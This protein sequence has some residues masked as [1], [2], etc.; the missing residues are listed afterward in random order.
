MIYL[1]SDTHF[2]HKNIIRYCNRPF[3]NVDV[4]NNVIIENWNSRVKKDDIVYHLGDVALGNKASQP[5]LVQQLNGKI[6][7]IR[8]NHDPKNQN[9]AETQWFKD[10]GFVAIYEFLSGNFVG[11]TFTHT[12]VHSPHT[13]VSA[14]TYFILHGHLH[15]SAERRLSFWKGKTYFDVG[16]D[17]NDYYPISLSEVEAILQEASYPKIL[18]VNQQL[19][20]SS[21]E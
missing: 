21:S 11:G 19:V 2:N 4:M 20:E 12:L 17:G 18:T 5:S 14:D 16:V 10:C 13:K 7:L 9:L 15:F 6:V 3:P 8:G 1:T